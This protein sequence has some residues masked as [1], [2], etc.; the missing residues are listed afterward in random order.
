MPD[1]SFE[2]EHGGIVCGADEVGRGPLAGPVVAAAV[3]IPHDIREMGFVSE[4]TDSKK[5]SAKKRQELSALIHEHCH[6][7]IAELSPKDIDRINIFQASLEAMKHAIETLSGITPDH[8]LIDGK[9]CPKDLSC[10]SQAV[11]KGDLKSISIAAASIIAKVKRDHIMKDLAQMHPHYG[12]ERNSGYPTKEHREAIDKHGVTEF[13]RISFAPV[14]NYLEFGN[15][16]PQR[17]SAA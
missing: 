9:H 6:I 15:T 5:L 14:R 8:A 17:V 13:H 3:I 11:I 2:D 4:L 7:S 16:N 12:W 1:F 10:S